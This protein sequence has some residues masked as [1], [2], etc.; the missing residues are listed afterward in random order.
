MSPRVSCLAAGVSDRMW[1]LEKLVEQASL[2]RQANIRGRDYEV[3]VHQ[4]T[5][6]VWTASGTFM[7]EWHQAKGRT[8][9]R[10]ISQ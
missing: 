9:N 8:E 2:K 6:S 10:A 3:T 1:S 4:E 7:D 5:P